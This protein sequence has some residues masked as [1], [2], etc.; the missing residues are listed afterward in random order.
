MYQNYEKIRNEK[1]MKDVDVA[2]GFGD[3]TQIK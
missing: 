3:R 2:R 1:G